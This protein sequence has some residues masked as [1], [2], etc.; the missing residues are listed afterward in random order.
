MEAA[1]TTLLNLGFQLVLIALALFGGFAAASHLAS[2]SQFGD[3]WKFACIL[4]G[5]L[6]LGF[7]AAVLIYRKLDDS[8]TI[9]LERAYGDLRTRAYLLLSHAELFEEKL[10]K[11]RKVVV[12]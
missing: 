8:C 4:L 10:D 9:D 7:G 3:L 6:S 11:Q 1:M 12:S 2:H 5:T